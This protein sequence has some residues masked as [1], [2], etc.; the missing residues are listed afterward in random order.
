[1]A[2]FHYIDK[3][4][5]AK[6]PFGTE[7]S[8]ESEF[9]SMLSSDTTTVR[10]QKYKPGE[11]VTG[12]VLSIGEQFIFVDLGGKNAGALPKEEL[13]AMGAAF[14]KLGDEVT[15]FVKSDSG[16]EVVLSKQLRRGESDDTALRMAYENGVPVEA[17]VD[18]VVKGGFEVSIAGKRGFVPQSQMDLLPIENPEVFIGTVQRF[19]ITEFKPRNLVLSRKS[20]LREERAEQV[21]ELLRTLQVGQMVVGTVT[22]FMAFGAFVDIGGVEALIPL[23]EMSWKRLKNAE[24]VLKIGEKVTAKILKIEHSP[25]L[26]IGLSIKDA[27]ED[28]WIS[29][30]TRLVPGTAVP[31]VITRLADFGAFVQ[32]FEG[33]EGMAH[34]SQLTWEKRIQHP[35]EVVTGGQEVTAHILGVDLDGRKLSLSLKGPMPEELAQ[36]L[37]NKSKGGS[38]S[39]MT[40]ADKS[41]LAEWKSFKDLQNKAEISHGGAGALAAAFGSARKKKL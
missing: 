11:T 1:M 38:D 40:D 17:K 27:G 29:Y 19:V 36:K 41:D 15:A 21:Q 4:D 31:G 30:A 7:E 28:P 3:E 39:Q 32:I 35:R 6:D 20:L 2:R 26:K 33:V 13:T 24:E 5:L 8:V 23:S 25:K 9:Q 34:V 14:P 12:T 10:S 37:A 16:S 18:K 22:K